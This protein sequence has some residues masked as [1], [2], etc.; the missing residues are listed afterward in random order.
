[1]ATCFAALLLT[2]SADDHTHIDNDSSVTIVCSTSYPSSS[3]AFVDRTLAPGG[4]G[5]SFCLS[6]D[7]SLVFRGNLHAHITS[8]Y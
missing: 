2:C 5:R 3:S 6:V 1:M 8:R 7:C 4:S